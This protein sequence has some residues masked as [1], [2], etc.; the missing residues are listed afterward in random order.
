MNLSKTILVLFK[1]KSKEVWATSLI[2]PSGH[3]FRSHGDLIIIITINIIIMIIIM[4]I[5]IIRI[6]IILIMLIVIITQ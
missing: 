5:I 2:P 3:I 6:M 4:I 1:T